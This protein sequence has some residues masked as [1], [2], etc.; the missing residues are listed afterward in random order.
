MEPIGTLSLPD[1]EKI[2]RLHEKLSNLHAG[3]R[4]WMAEIIQQWFGLE[5]PHDWHIT[6]SLKLYGGTDMF[7]T[8]RTGSGKTMLMLTSMLACKVMNGHHI[9]VVIYLTWSLMDDQV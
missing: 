1:H 6:N 7:L 9:V 4:Q 3:S 5:A 2:T 8:S